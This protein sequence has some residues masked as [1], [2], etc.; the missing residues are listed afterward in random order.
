L[1]LVTTEWLKRKREG[2]LVDHRQNGSGKTIASVYSVRP[3]PGAPVSTPLRWDELRKGL[4][5]RA[6]TMEVAL[7]R[8]AKH[9]DLFAPVLEDP[10]PLAPAARAL[11]ALG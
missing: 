6:F 3:K 7:D 11:A 8:C 10:R 5:P 2:V 1:G 9:G 4:T